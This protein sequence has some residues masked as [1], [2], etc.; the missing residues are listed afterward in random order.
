MS[1]LQA[2]KRL[3]LVPQTV[4]LL[5][6]TFSGAS[7]TPSD[8]GP[9]LTTVTGTAVVSGG[10]L[11]KSDSTELL[12]RCAGLASNCVQQIKF[13]FGNSVAASRRVLL[14]ARD[15]QA[16][17]R[18]DVAVS[19]S[20][21]TVVIS[22][23]A[24]FAPTTIASAAQA[25]S[26]STDYWL[27]WSVSG[28]ALRVWWSTDG[29]TFTEIISATTAL[30]PSQTGVALALTDNDAGTTVQADDYLVWRAP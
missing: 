14:F 17:N 23:R 10:V 22:S 19:R 3:L 25:M 21:G 15:D 9:N 4:P 12:V 7:L 24:A 30:Y 6:H 11:K 13:N 1:V 26:D 18:L 2:R 5:L 29:G 20:A 28:T 27:R 8:L 16:G